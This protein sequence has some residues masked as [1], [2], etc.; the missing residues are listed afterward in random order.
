M[1]FIEPV[2]TISAK[3]KSI[4]ESFSIFLF[5]ETEWTKHKSQR[6]RIAITGETEPD[7]YERN[8]FIL[9]ACKRE[10]KK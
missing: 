7:N 5:P 6:K 9:R 10:Q 1:L 2:V 3:E 8:G 4:Q